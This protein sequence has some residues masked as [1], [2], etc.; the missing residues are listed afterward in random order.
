[1]NNNDFERVDMEVSNAESAPFDADD[2]SASIRDSSKPRSSW[3]PGGDADSCVSDE[4][5]GLLAASLIAGSGD[6]SML[7]AAAPPSTNVALTVP[8]AYF[9]VSLD[10]K[11]ADVS[12]PPSLAAAF[13][14]SGKAAV[15]S[16][17]G[18]SQ[19]PQEKSRTAEENIA[20]PLHSQP[21]DTGSELVLQRKT[22]AIT[23]IPK[24]RQT[25]SPTPASS[26][27]SASREA[28]PS[29][30]SPTA[31]NCGLDQTRIET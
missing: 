18:R 19:P 31:M 2:E 12:P 29:S 13:A 24:M 30:S 16:N 20:L 5:L 27:S 28:S 23:S 9:H 25:H 22:S 4:K 8:T 3:G 14:L 7:G 1:M 11:P 26:S 17:R 15:L 21:L 10:S 6:G